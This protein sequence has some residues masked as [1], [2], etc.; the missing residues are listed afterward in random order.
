MIENGA[1]VQTTPRTDHDGRATETDRRDGRPRDLGVEMG[2]ERIT[3]VQEDAVAARSSAGR[4]HHAQQRSYI[5]HALR[6]LAD[7]ST[8]AEA[9]LAEVFATYRAQ[10][11][12]T[13][14]AWLAA[15]RSLGRS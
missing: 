7:A 11:A 2:F 8:P 13:T 4:M 5:G 14:T 9:A 1:R 3:E 12:A 10:E 15:D 6:F